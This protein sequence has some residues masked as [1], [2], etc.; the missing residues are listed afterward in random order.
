VP[1]PELSML[2][3][4]SEGPEVFYVCPGRSLDYA[5][6]SRIIKK[7]NSGFRREVPVRSAQHVQYVGGRRYDEDRLFA[8]SFQYFMQLACILCIVFFSERNPPLVGT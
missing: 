2:R 3:R 5:R 6:H 7:Y 8:Q 1:R 4:S